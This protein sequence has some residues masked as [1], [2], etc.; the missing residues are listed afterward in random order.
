MNSGAKILL[1]EDHEDTARAVA[2]ILETTGNHVS[3][4]FTIAD[5]LGVLV[6]ESFD[7]IIC[8]LSLPDGTGIKLINGVR[9]FCKTPA[10]AL[11][12]YAGPEDAKRCLEAGFDRH[13]AKPLQFAELM[14]SIA[15]L[16]GGMCPGG[17]PPDPEPDQLQRTYFRISNSS[18]V[19]S[20]V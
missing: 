6:R 10:I 3:L 17:L 2:L 11:T 1:I 5:A 4:A 20:M 18:P 19:D 9:A 13:H 8:D 16:T 14:Q 15:E 7:I 12:G